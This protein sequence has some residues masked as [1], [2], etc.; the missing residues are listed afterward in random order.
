MK[1]EKNIV[2]AGTSL[3]ELMVLGGWGSIKMVIR[4][5]HLSSDNLKEASDRIVECT[6]MLTWLKKLQ[7][8][9]R[10]LLLMVELKCDT[11]LTT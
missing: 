2:Q 4:Y 6:M 5:G 7:T 9:L 10:K 3:Q 8:W 11:V 1:V